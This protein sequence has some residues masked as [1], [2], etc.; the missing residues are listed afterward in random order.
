MLA[1]N[2][3]VEFS[4]LQ[5]A[6]FSFALTFSQLSSKE[7]EM[8]LDLIITLSENCLL[9]SITLKYFINVEFVF[10]KRLTISEKSYLLLGV[11][12]SAGIQGYNKEEN[13]TV[14]RIA[15]VFA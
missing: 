13:D 11:P 14:L 6:L 2:S 3:S 12:P 10:V 5:I 7:N 1:G 8:F 15:A 4:P 9:V